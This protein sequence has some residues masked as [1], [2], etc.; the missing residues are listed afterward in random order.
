MGFLLTEVYL[1]EWM[2]ISMYE[3]DPYFEGYSIVYCRSSVRKLRKLM[4]PS[5]CD[6]SRKSPIPSSTKCLHVL[7]GSLYMVRAVFSKLAYTHISACSTTSRDPIVPPTS[8][9]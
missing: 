7:G 8:C 5:A 2:R 4:N 3:K 1:S 6:L 9:E